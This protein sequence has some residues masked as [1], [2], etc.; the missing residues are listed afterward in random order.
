MKQLLLALALAL[1]FV[2][3]KEATAPPTLTAEAAPSGFQVQKSCTSNTVAIGATVTCTITISAP[4]APCP[5]VSF[6]D[7]MILTVARKT[8]VRGPIPRMAG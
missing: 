7:P 4:F 1:V 2:M 8:P 3:G 6:I 5:C